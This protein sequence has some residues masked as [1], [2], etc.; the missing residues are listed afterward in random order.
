[1]QSEPTSS[2]SSSSP[3]PK[4]S[5]MELPP[6][7]PYPLNARGR[8]R[9]I[10]RVC[11]RAGGKKGNS[12]LTTIPEFIIHKQSDEYQIISWTIL[13]QSISNLVQQVT[14]EDKAREIAKKILRLNIMRGKGLLCKYIMSVQLA[15]T[16]KTHIYALFISLI[17]LEFPDVG[18]LLL[19]R[20]LQ[21]FK[22]ANKTKEKCEYLTSVLFISY[23]IIYEVVSPLMA[24]KLLSFLVKLPTQD[25]IDAAFVILNTCGHKMS[26]SN[27]KELE[28]LI[29]L[30][31]STSAYNIRSG[32][33]I[34][35]MIQIIMETISLKNVLKFKKPMMTKFR[36]PFN[37]SL[38]S[39]IDPH[40]ELDYYSYDPYY[41][42]S[43]ELYELFRTQVLESDDKDEYVLMYDTETYNKR[44]KKKNKF[45]IK[46][47]GN[48]KID[49]N[50]KSLQEFVQMILDSSTFKYENCAYQLMKIKLNP[51]QEME[52]CLMLFELCFER[53]S[54]NE[55]LGYTTQIF[56][57]LNRFLIEPFEKLFVDTYA[58]VNSFDTIK[59]RNIAKYFAQL[60][61]SDT[62]SWKVLSVIRLNGIET[63]ASTGNF[64][65]HLFHELSEHMGEEDLKYRV[66]DPSLKYAFEGIFFGDKYNNSK[67]SFD[68]FSSIGL[69]GL[70]KTFEK[71]LIF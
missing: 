56:C 60:L 58:I 50:S 23:L 70:I 29:N 12:K 69:G 2:S 27:K 68:F 22:V 44:N 71:S 57:Q 55:R 32:K 15:S 54:Y 46:H 43:E 40:M 16:D 64:L 18:G 33:K 59:L 28:N 35:R 41:E 30:G 14:S 38:E 36:T 45:V 19:V 47:S 11:P 1:M 62:I 52:I 26:D 67:F 7:P 39:Q 63:T 20:C 51:G 65:K 37:I 5:A 10:R 24:V 8:Y 9:H 31:P 42:Y 61:Y 53:D 25:S 48:P 6:P 66:E 34:R 17:Y 4:S 13:Q 49:K 3:Q 21:Q